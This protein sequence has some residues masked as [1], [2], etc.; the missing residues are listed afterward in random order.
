MRVGLLQ[1]AERPKIS[2][3]DVLDQGIDQGKV[4]AGVEQWCRQRAWRLLVKKCIKHRR[5]DKAAS[6]RAATANCIRFSVL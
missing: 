6:I 2:D 4:L 5:G 3:A 1:S